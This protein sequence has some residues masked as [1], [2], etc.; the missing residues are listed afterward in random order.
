MYYINIMCITAL[1]MSKLITMF[2]I[3]KVR[4]GRLVS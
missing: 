2:E 3:K 4:K 1:G